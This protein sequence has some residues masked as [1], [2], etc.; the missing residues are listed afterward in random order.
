M[1]AEDLSQVSSTSTTQFHPPSFRACRRNVRLSRTRRRGFLA[2]PVTE[3][4]RAHICSRSQVHCRQ[5]Q[6]TCYLWLSMCWLLKFGCDRSPAATCVKKCLIHSTYKC[7]EGS[8]TFCFCASLPA[9]CAFP[10]F[11]LNFLDSADPLVAGDECTNEY[12]ASRH[13]LIEQY[14]VRKFRP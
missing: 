4:A 1:G 7:Q 10:G 2:L 6:K 11:L 3:S 8:D 13:I 14:V 9:L 5:V 12:G